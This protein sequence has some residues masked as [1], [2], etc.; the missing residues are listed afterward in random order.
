MFLASLWQ[1][2]QNR[3]SWETLTDSMRIDVVEMKEP[4]SVLQ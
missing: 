1:L 4:V 2:S 3:I